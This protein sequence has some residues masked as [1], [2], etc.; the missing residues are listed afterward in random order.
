[1]AQGS[2]IFSILLVAITMTLSALGIIVRL[3]DAYFHHEHVF[4][5]I[6]GKQKK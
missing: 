2:F 1:M 6:P 3:P 5:G 4:L